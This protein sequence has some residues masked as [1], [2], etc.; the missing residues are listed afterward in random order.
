MRNQPFLFDT[1]NNPPPPGR[2]LL[3]H[4]DMTSP[5]VTLGGGDSACSAR[6]F[7][8]HHAFGY[9]YKGKHDRGQLHT[10]EAYS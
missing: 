8:S 1:A 4:G 3:A 2:G 5:T 6:L 7:V 10:G 9:K